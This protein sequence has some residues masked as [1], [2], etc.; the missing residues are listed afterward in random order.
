MI[1]RIFHA[2]VAKFLGVV[3]VYEIP[4]R[5]VN[6]SVSEAVSKKSGNALIHCVARCTMLLQ[7]YW[8][9]SRDYK[10]AK[11]VLRCFAPTPGLPPTSPAP[12]PESIPREPT[13]GSLDFTENFSSRL[14]T[15]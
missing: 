1:S 9:S 6:V 4:F 8:W 5:P 15:L 10:T 12:K 14:R 3:G 7:S 13:I 2:K 11:R